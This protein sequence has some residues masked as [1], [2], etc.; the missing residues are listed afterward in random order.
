MQSLAFSLAHK[1]TDTGSFVHVHN[2]AVAR[3]FTRGFDLTSRLAEGSYR[4][5]AA[6]TTPTI[7]NA[8][9]RGKEDRRRGG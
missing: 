9:T 8:I 4:V 2:V 7:S 6:I 5:S 3:A 1:C